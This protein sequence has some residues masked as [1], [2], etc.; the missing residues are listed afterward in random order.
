MHQL[1][2]IG[3]AVDHGRMEQRALG[4]LAVEHFGA[5]R[6]GVVDARLEEGGRA[7]VDDGADICFRIHRVAAFQRL[8]LLDNQFG[9]GIGDALDH[10]DALHRRAA[11]AGILGRTG[12][13]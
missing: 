4:P 2:G 6:H 10:Q 12:D 11:L 1:A 5:L 8:R 9:E 7:G 13:G 3:D